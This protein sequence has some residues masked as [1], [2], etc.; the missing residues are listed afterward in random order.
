[1]VEHFHAYTNNGNIVDLFQI[2]FHV[3]LG[4]SA[5]MQDSN[6]MIKN[7]QTNIF[8]AID[9]IKSTNKFK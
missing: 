1:M 9:I 3:V 5:I 7:I 6:S 2:L 8:G 4:H